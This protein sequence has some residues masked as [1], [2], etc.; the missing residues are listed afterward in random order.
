MA[1]SLRGE[2]NSNWKGGRIVASNGY[3]MVK[4]PGHHLADCRGYVYEHRI[5]AEEKLGRHLLPGEVV[6]HV[7]GIKSDN[8]PENI[9]VL[10]ST[11]HHFR[12]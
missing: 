11:A 9:E 7:N 6:H 4:R 8:R 12:P 5:V 1:G 10:S 3:V 2:R